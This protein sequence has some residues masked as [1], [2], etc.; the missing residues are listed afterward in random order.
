MPLCQTP[1]PNGVI[2]G[3]NSKSRSEEQTTKQNQ[4]A[5]LNISQFT[6]EIVLSQRELNLSNKNNIVTEYFPFRPFKLNA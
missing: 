2:Q 3:E 1:I 4:Q 6:T 5:L